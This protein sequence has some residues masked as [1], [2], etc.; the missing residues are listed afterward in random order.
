MFVCLYVRNTCRMRYID[1]KIRSRLQWFYNPYA[2]SF[3]GQ[4][5]VINEVVYQSVDG[6]VGTERLRSSFGLSYY[7][8]HP[9]QVYSFFTWSWV[10][11][12]YLH[13]VLI[14]ESTTRVRDF[15]VW[16]Q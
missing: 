16:V 10:S 6:L 3:L 4:R 1:R 13:T 14:L 12:Y 15:V 9:F 5:L 2:Q 11:S 7:Q 8:I